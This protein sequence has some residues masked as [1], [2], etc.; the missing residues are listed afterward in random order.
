MKIQNKY[1]QI[2]AWAFWKDR[3]FSKEEI[4]KDKYN[5]NVPNFCCDNR[6]N[7]VILLQM[8]IAFH[9]TRKHS[10]MKIFRR[11]KKKTDC[12]GRDLILYF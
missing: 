12:S 4:K 10:A 9:G 8:Q 6:Q 11:T 5:K 3:Q 2:K 1:P 7:S